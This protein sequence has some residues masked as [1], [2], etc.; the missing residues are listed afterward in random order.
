M[1]RFML[2]VA[3]TA[4]FA[5][6]AHAS[7]DTGSWYVTPSVQWWDL[8]EHRHAA[9]HVAGQFALGY[10]YD[11]NWAVEAEGGG[12]SFASHCGCALTLAVVLV[13]GIYKFAPGEAL[14]PYVIAGIGAMHDHVDRSPSTTGPAAEAGFGFLSAP[15]A[16]ARSVAWQLRGELKYRREFSDK[17]ATTTSVGDV[18]GGIGLQLS[19]R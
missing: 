3:A 5:G 16:L 19:F 10:A 1:K 14:R 11:E 13:D 12:A 9:S 4:A 8:D 15:R 2:M 18:V 17:T 6:I 7:D